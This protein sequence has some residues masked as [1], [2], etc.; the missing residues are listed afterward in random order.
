MPVTPVAKEYVMAIYALAEE[1]KPVIG[2]RLADRLGVTPP[3]V[4]QTLERLKRDELVLVEPRRGIVLTPAGRELAEEALR[5]QRLSERWLVE[6]LGLDW[7]EAHAAS[8]AME[9]AISPRI[10]ERLDAMLG[11]PTTCPHGNPI[12]ASG[13]LAGPE[14]GVWP[15]DRIEAGAAV[16]LERIAEDGAHA[17]ELLTYLDKHELRPGARVTVAAVEPWAH[18]ITLRRGDQEMVLGT[19]VAGQLWVRRLTA[20]ELARGMTPE[21]SECPEEEA[22]VAD[23]ESVESA[24]PA[25]HQIGDRFV[26]GQRTPCGMCGEAFVEMYPRLQELKERAAS[27]RGEAVSVACPE[28]G[29]VTFRVRFSQSPA[30]EVGTGA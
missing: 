27:R 11:H 24:C 18:T 28:H 3:T 2:A 29:N 23:V 5:R 14:A 7:A 17:R 9:S 25:G 1:G 30:A 10:A 15:L 8:R 16:V 13:D 22:F 4:H 12:A 26:F 20:E 21:A 6:M 19:R